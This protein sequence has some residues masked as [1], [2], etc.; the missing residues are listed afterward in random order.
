MSDS[1]LCITKSTGS[2]HI[3]LFTPLYLSF[4]GSKSTLMFP[5]Q[6]FQ[7]TINFS[8]AEEKIHIHRKIPFWVDHMQTFVQICEF[9]AKHSRFEVHFHGQEMAS[10]FRAG[11]NRNIEMGTGRIVQKV[12]SDKLLSMLFSVVIPFSC[13]TM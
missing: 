1:G 6:T 13:N 3:Y 9:E 7:N 11:R 10:A 8:G 12:Q 4:L 5:S 2:L